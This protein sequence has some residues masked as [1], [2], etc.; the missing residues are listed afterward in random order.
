MQSRRFAIRVQPHKKGSYEWLDWDNDVT[1]I[2]GIADA[3]DNLPLDSTESVD[4]DGDGIGDNADPGSCL[5]F[6]FLSWVGFCLGFWF[7][8]WFSQVLVTKDVC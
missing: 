1:V 7:L 5:G 2:P 8:S 6:G 3:A 4:T